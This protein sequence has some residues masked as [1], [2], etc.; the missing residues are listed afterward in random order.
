MIRDIKAL[1]WLPLSS[2]IQRL[3][4]PHEQAFLRQADGAGESEGANARP[5]RVRRFCTPRLTI[6]F[7]ITF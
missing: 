2:A 1:E 6:E 3:S 7:R 5:R 4:V